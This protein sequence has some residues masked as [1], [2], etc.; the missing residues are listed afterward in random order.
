MGT[1]YLFQV[2]FAPYGDQSKRQRKVIQKGFG[3]SSIRQYQPLI[4]VETH[5]FL[6][7]LLRSPSN[8]IEHMRRC[9]SFHPSLDI[10][11]LM[12]SV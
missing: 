1:Q 12:F 5:A 11:Y 9:V 3:P 2:A 4:E 7:R 6:R 8:Y 10:D